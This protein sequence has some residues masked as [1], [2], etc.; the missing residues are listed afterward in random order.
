[1]FGE[2]PFDCTGPAIFSVI[3]HRG[4]PLERILREIPCSR[5][6]IDPC[7]EPFVP[8]AMLRRTFV[9]SLP[10]VAACT[11]TRKVDPKESPVRSPPEPT[12]L[13]AHELPNDDFWRWDHGPEGQSDRWGDSQAQRRMLVTSEGRYELRELTIDSPNAHAANT[14]FGLVHTDPQG[15][16]RWVTEL[17]RPFVPTGSMVST[18]DRLYATHHCAIASGA[19]VSAVDRASGRVLW[20]TELEGLGPI[21]HDKV[22]NE[23]QIA[24]DARGLVIYG[25][26]AQGQ[27]IEVLDPQTGTQRRLTRPDPRF[28]RM[29][30]EGKAPEAPFDFARGPSELVVDDT[31]YVVTSPEDPQHPTTLERIDMHQSERQSVWITSLPGPPS[32]S[33]D[34]AV[35]R[36]LDGVL[37]IAR[38]CAA[39]SGAEL[40]AVDPDSGS[41]VRTIA[42]HALGPIAHSEYFNE[43]ELDERH[44]HLVVR[45]REA[46]GRYIEVIDPQTGLARVN[47][48]YWD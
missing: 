9:L 24:L 26:E 47:L 4:R 21:G 23:T 6:Q 43:V 48:R 27:Y 36:M 22:R 31:H 28:C 5:A 30:W 33:C 32:S 1:M 45:G 8:A 3:R 42:V 34:Q 37:W 41:P 17:S 7:F 25:N 19:S 46:A 44:G 38:Y 2:A 16:I 14:P 11:P 12:R 18:G 35:M 13:A 39:S 29:Q 20:T 40:V 15:E 10:I